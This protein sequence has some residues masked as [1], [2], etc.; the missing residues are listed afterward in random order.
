MKLK[1]EKDHIKGPP[2]L[3]GFEKIM[4]IIFGSLIRM[5]IF[6]IVATIKLIEKIRNKYK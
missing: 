3:K 2:E 1:E 5:V 6:L 4:A